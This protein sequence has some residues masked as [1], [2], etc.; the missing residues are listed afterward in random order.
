MTSF[1]ARTVNAAQ[2]PDLTRHASTRMQ[3]RGIGAR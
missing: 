1:E 2:V 3:Q